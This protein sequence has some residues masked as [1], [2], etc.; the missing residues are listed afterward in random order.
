MARPW[1]KHRNAQT[2]TWNHYNHEKF[3]ETELPPIKAFCSKLRLS[4]ISKKDYKHAKHVY[5]SFNC[6]TFQD[7]RTLYIKSDV[8]LLA[9]VF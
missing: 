2:H 1:Q 3:K 4:G 6:S 8:I 9:D 7:Y 5:K